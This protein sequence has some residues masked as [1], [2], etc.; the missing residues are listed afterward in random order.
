MAVLC[1]EG[2]RMGA[3]GAGGGDAYQIEKSLRF[4]GDDD[5]HLNRTFDSGGSTTTWTFSFWIKGHDTGQA[6]YVF[7]GGTGTS[8]YII[9]DAS[10]FRFVS[11]A[12]DL[13]TNARYRDPSAWYHFVCVADTTDST[14]NDKTRVYVN[15]TRLAVA[16]FATHSQPSASDDL[17]DF[18]SAAV[19][20]I[21]RQGVGNQQDFMLADI[22]FIDGT[23]LTAS[24]FGETNATTG[25][26][27][28]IEYSGSYGTNGFHLKFDNTSDL[29]EDSSGNDND[30]TVNNLT[31]TPGQVFSD[32]ADSTA[33]YLYAP[34][35]MA[36][37]GGIVN[38]AFTYSSVKATCTIPT[39]VTWSTSFEV[40]VL[41]YGGVGVIEVNDDDCT[42]LITGG[43]TKT[44]YNLNSIVGSSGTFEKIA[45]SDV[46]TNYLKLFAVRLDGVILTDETVLTSSISTDT[47]TPFDDEGNGTG[48]YCTWNPLQKGNGTLSN[49]NLEYVGDSS[50]EQTHGTIGGL[51][52]G[53]WYHEFT[54]LNDPVSQ[55]SSGLY[56]VYGWTS[57]PDLTTAYGSTD[58]LGFEDTG[59]YRNFGSQ[60]DS[61]TTLVADDVL[62][63]AVDLD[64]NTFNIRKNNSS[65]LSGTIGG[66]AGRPLWPF[67]MNYNGTQGKAR[68]NF[69]QR[70]FAYTPP[71]DHKALNTYNL[72]DPTIAIPS[73]HFDVGLDAGADILST[74]NGLTDG[75][76]FVWIKDR[77][78]SD[79]HI[80]FNRIND[81]GMD[82][83]P[84][85]RSNETDS[86]S[87]CGTYSA[88]SGD[89]VAWVWNAG[90]ANVTN[91][92]SA[93]S[94]GTIDSTYRANTDAGFSIVSYTGTGSNE[95]VA[96]GLNATPD[97]ILIKNRDDSD[98]WVVYHNTQGIGKYG[99]LD[100][101]V[102]WS[103]TSASTYFNTAPTSTV[104]GIGTAG[105]VNTNTNN[106]Q[107]YCWSEVEG[108][109]KF[110]S[111]EGNGDNDGSFVH[112]GF[113]PRY[114]LTKASSH[115]SSWQLWDTE[116]Q[117][118][119]VNA[120]TLAPDDSAAET[121]TA[122]YSV[123][124][125]SNGFKFR[126]YG[127]SS[128]QSGYTYIFAA[129][130]AAPFK[131][132]NAQ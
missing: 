100:T 130:A 88:P 21:N 131:Y 30:W 67:H 41:E 17:G 92:A 59:W 79:D 25:Q 1:N 123:D 27:V 31:G 32:G 80:L 76:D 69:G 125:L 118:Y 101:N 28:P 74:A 18:G 103:T 121:G 87:T 108:F 55:A 116:R 77:A 49:G 47:P 104:F 54:L 63:F 110:G 45:I 78:N 90:S 11:S 9:M 50:W 43:S 93:T 39:P 8:S 95:T 2:I 132:S 4:N 97:F 22:H 106:Y 26:W 13:K 112:T 62:S 19:H 48:N 20:Y 124:M 35:S 129:F 61:S 60:T 46:G 81:T 36:F 94:I 82:G 7:T 40:S 6:C 3:S 38:G 107:A 91:D 52:S 33:M 96:H 70:A 34:W 83:T 105:N 73:K 51:T 68:V 111:Y 12:H 86:E 53:K 23:A 10:Q 24:D 115:G 66:T 71:T 75:A 109:S 113:A 65:V 56:N 119:N 14:D 102:V 127:S 120:N 29:G 64:D 126:M 15:G 42:S 89:S 114:L 117:P 57:N 128:N 44:W 84:H 98:S 72:P 5:A 16:D 99:H 122:G 37:D 58:W 85:L